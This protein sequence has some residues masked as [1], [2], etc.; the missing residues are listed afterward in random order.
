MHGCICAILNNTPFIGFNQYMPACGMSKIQDLMTHFG[1]T[2]FYFNEFVS[3]GMEVKDLVNKLLS[4][5]WNMN[6][7]N[8]KIQEFRNIE[9]EFMRKIHDCLSV[10]VA[11]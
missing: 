11:L 7:L 10:G 5:S 4:S 6:T 8:K 3:S 9:Q 2:E 1:I